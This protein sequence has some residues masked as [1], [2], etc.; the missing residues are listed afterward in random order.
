[1]INIGDLVRIDLYTGHLSPMG[2]KMF[3]GMNGLIVEVINVNDKWAMIKVTDELY[4]SIPIDCL[5]PMFTK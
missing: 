2:R 1:M 5:I 4:K 3:S